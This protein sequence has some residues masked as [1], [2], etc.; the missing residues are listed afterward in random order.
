MLTPH[1]GPIREELALGPGWPA[2][3]C[4]SIRS[5]PAAQGAGR[6][7]SVADEH[8]LGLP[9]RWLAQLECGSRSRR[10]AT[11]QGGGSTVRKRRLSAARRASGASVWGI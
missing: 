9:T 5:G 3:G 10:A 7:A 2:R 8:V 1:P 6:A 11:R 4:P